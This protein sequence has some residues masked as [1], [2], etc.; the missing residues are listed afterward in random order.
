MYHAVPQFI[1]KKTACQ[2]TGPHPHAT[3]VTHRTSADMFAM[4]DD[5]L[6]E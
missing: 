1:I 2:I 5:V 3:H 4:F 6:N